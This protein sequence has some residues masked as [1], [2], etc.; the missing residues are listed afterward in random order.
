VL[1]IEPSA[2]LLSITRTTKAAD[3]TPFEFSHDLFHA[4]RTSILARTVGAEGAAHCARETGRLVDLA[5][6]AGAD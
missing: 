4:D 6:K 5:S 1:N 3:G 2:P